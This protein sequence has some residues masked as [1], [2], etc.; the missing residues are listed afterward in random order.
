MKLKQKMQLMYQNDIH[1][2]NVRGQSQHFRLNHN[3]KQQMTYHR[4]PFI[5]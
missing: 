5:C 3:H 4:F 2:F 1:L